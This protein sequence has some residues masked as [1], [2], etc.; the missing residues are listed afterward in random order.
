M[1]RILLLIFCIV[2]TVSYAQQ[3][4]KINTFHVVD[5]NTKK[6][7]G[8]ATINIL[9]A[10]LAIATESDGVF[11]IPGNLAAMRDTIILNAQ[12]YIPLKLP[13]ST[14]AT[15]DTIRL[16]RMIPKNQ[17]IQTKFS[18]KRTLNDYL[19]DDIGLYAG[20]A[21]DD[22]PFNYLQIAQHFVT[23]AAT[24]KL[25]SITINKPSD[26]L[27]TKFRV[28]IY[29]TDPATG[30][31]GADLYDRI[32][33][34]DNEEYV[35]DY[36]NRRSSYA[37]YVESKS[38]IIDFR[39]DNI[40]IP[41]KGFFVAVEWLRDFFNASKAP[42]YNKVTSKVDTAIVYRPFIGISPVK[43]N[44]L[45]IWVMQLDRTWKTYDHFYP[46]GTDLAIKATVEY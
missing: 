13:I 17:G 27:L 6:P 23:D 42:V 29:D 32:I 46:F 40:I 8:Y 16:Y 22:A 15:M 41:S 26:W 30:G 20:V 19:A 14:L 7:I 28:R 21:T 43:G 31:P 33:D 45:N 10:K 24:S 18:A 9:K 38:T 36:L 12:T 44:Q 34:I 1:K 11:I 35:N 4:P 3:A 37:S 25:A 2:S 39:K 5:F